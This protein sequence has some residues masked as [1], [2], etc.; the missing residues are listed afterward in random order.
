MQIFLGGPDGLSS[1]KRHIVGGLL[2]KVLSFL[3]FQ[4]W[5]IFFIF[6]WVGS[7]CLGPHA[8]FLYWFRMGVRWRK[9]REYIVAFSSLPSFR[10]SFF[11]SCCLKREGGGAGSYRTPRSIVR[12]D[13][14]AWFLRLYLLVVFFVNEFFISSRLGACVCGTYT[15]VH[16]HDVTLER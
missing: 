13:P 1:S 12:S 15:Y 9:K 8:Y 10:G 7:L 3:L 2:V 5:M 6:L 14:S 4:G 16:T 11:L